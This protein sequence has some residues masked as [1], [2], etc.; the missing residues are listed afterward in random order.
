VSSLSICLSPP[1]RIPAGSHALDR[2]AGK[3]G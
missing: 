1:C 2:V 3:H